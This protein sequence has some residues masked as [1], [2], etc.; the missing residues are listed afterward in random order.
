MHPRPHLAPPRR[1]HLEPQL[2]AREAPPQE[3]ELYLQLGPIWTGRPE[4]VFERPE[5][6]LL[7]GVGEELD[8]PVRLAQPVSRVAGEGH[9]LDG[10]AAVQPQET[11]LDHIRT[12]VVKL[13]R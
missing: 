10:G 4:G 11:H 7:P 5:V 6:T 9:I 12:R 3:A 8:V 2:A 13:V 1:L